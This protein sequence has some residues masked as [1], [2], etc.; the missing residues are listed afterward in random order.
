MAKITWNFDGTDT[1][2]AGNTSPFSFKLERYK[3]SN[4]FEESLK[5]SSFVNG[6]DN[7][8]IVTSI[9]DLRK[10]IVQLKKYGVLL[11]TIEFH[12]LQ[13][14]IEDNYLTL[15]PVTMSLA[16]DTRVDDLL[17]AAIEY[18]DGNADLITNDLCYVPVNE[19]NSIAEDCGFYKYEIKA[20]RGQLNS[21]GYI[22]TSG[23]RLAI[24][25]RIKDKPTRVIAFKRNKLGV[26]IPVSTKNKQSKKSDADE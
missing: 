9:Q 25:V 24:T 6:A 4:T 26:K 21:Q 14:K 17:A 19:F 5:I 22:R 12:D 8:F 7:G 13:Q 2:D 18:V 20:L 10:D 3:D 15:K 11:S 1:I 23:N 16:S